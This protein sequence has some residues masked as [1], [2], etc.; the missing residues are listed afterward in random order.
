MG[1]CCFVSID[2]DR[3]AKSKGKQNNNQTDSAEGAST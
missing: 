2:L 3:R 1:V